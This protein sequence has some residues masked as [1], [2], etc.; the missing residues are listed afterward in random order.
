M[1]GPVAYT[2]TLNQAEIDRIGLQVA[3]ASV[4]D[5]ARRVLN[6]AD[7]LTPVDTGNLRAHNQMRIL[8]VGKIVQGEVFNE[9]SYA[10]SVHNGSKAH[11]EVITPKRAKAL[12]FVAAD[13][14]V[15]FARRVTVTVPARR[16]RPWLTRALT[17]VAVPEGY[18][19]V[20]LS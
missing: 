12:R 14:T 17:E 4:T 5:T 2:L 6:R 20:A 3:R 11:T 13:G 7:V 1:P 18:R 19:P 9:T 15:V 10:A 16:G 8:T